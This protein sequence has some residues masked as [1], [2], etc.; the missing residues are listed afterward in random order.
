M[1]LCAYIITNFYYRFAAQYRKSYVTARQTIT[2][3]STIFTAIPL[4]IQIIYMLT[5]NEKSF[6]GF[7]AFSL[8]CSL[9]HIFYPLLI[10]KKIVNL[11]S[12]FPLSLCFSA[13]T[14]VD[15]TFSY[16]FY[17]AIPLAV[18]MFSNEIASKN[19]VLRRIIAPY[20]FASLILQL[21][22]F[23]QKEVYVPAIAGAYFGTFIGFLISLI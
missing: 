15:R 3:L 10:G 22:Y 9:V 13:L 19:Y 17:L 21:L 8:V 7:F 6:S 5:P 18:F 14:A 12:L 2:P 11:A 4:I 1:G 20:L 23:P 16:L